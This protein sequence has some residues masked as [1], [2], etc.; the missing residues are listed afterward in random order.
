VGFI[1]V[2]VAIAAGTT[3][4]SLRH[5]G[6]LAALVYALHHALAKGLLFLAAGAVRDAAG[7]TAL[8][9]I[10][11]LGEQS[12]LFAVTALVGSLSLVGVPP[13][14]GFFGK[15]L[16]FEAAAVQFASAPTAVGVAVLA[17][18][19]AGAVLT[20]VYAMR[21]WIGSIWGTQTDRVLAGA[22]DASQVWLLAG[23]AAVVL[24][25]GLGFEPVYQFADAA[26]TAALDSSAYVETVLGGEPT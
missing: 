25:V 6:I 1:A 23:F 22:L 10:G 12:N 8:A 17:V 7:T 9:D 26:A 19:L 14:A 2:P 21:A 20:V 5:L 13:L 4:A 15:F 16:V 18:L 24:F 11:G 3:S